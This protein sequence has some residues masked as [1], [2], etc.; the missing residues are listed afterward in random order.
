MTRALLDAG[1]DPNVAGIGDSR[2]P[3]DLALERGSLAQVELLLERGARSK[4]EISRAMGSEIARGA[5]VKALL[6]RGSDVRG[7]KALFFPNRDPAEDVEL[8]R[9]LLDA[10][11]EI[12]MDQSGW[13]PLAYAAWNGN[14]ALVE[15]LLE[16]GAKTDI[17]IA[18]D[19][20]D[21]GIP[22]GSFPFDIAE[23]GNNPEIAERLKAVTPPKKSRRSRAK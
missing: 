11:A 5:K 14:L 2:T 17:P 13:T 22:K 21:V 6:A 12:D 15:L 1:A 4:Q 19:V 23:Y 16:R 18:Y 10:G 9:A 7:K 8:V 3:L 20:M